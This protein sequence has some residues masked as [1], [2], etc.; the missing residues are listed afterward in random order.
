[1]LRSAVMRTTPL[2]LKRS[3]LSLILQ[4]SSYQVSSSVRQKVLVTFPQYSSAL[5][6]SVNLAEVYRKL[7]TT[8]RVNP[9]NPPLNFRQSS[10]TR[11]LN[12]CSTSVNESLYEISDNYT[13]TAS[14]WIILHKVT[15]PNVLHSRE[16]STK[17]STPFRPKFLSAYSFLLNSTSS[18]A[19]KLWILNYFEGHLW[20]DGFGYWDKLLFHYATENLIF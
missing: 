9:L 5:C 13:S 4:I 12:F 3:S 6:W 11:H 10:L 20:V 8:R 1:M 18:G 2:I 14:I 16:K 17:N 19:Y 7:R 15:F